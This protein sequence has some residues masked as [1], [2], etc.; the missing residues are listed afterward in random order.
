MMSLQEWIWK[1]NST[2]QSASRL[3]SLMWAEQSICNTVPT[4]VTLIVATFCFCFNIEQPKARRT[5]FPRKKLV[6]LANNERF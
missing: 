2:E 1:T 3:E 6:G 5:D 4:L